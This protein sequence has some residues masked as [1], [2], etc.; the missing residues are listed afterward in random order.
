METIVIESFTIEMIANAIA[1]FQTIH[2]AQL[3]IFC[4]KNWIRKF[5]SEKILPGNVPSCYRRKKFV[6]R[7]KTFKLVRKFLSETRSRPI[8]YQYWRYHEQ[9]QSRGTY[10]IS[11]KF[12]SQSKCLEERKKLRFLLQM[13]HPVKHSLVRS[14]DALS[15]A[16]L[17]MNLEWCWERKDFSHQDLPTTLSVYTLSLYT[18]TWLSTISLST[19]TN[20]WYVVFFLI[21]SWKLEIY[22]P[23][24][25]TWTI[26]PLETYNSD[27]YSKIFIE[28]IH[29]DS[30]NTSGEKNFCICQYHSF[31]C[32][33]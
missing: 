11:Q 19:R 12:L 20:H 28:S 24:D 30:R 15:E 33:V 7:H 22:Q 16:M 10:T 31:W 32:D 8:N 2:F 4:G 9:S 18:Q 1:H 6:F 3:H 25:S 26:G 5:N 23:L 13:K 14:W 17:A 21:Q 29:I 27:C